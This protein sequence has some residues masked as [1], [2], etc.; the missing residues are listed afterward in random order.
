MTMGAGSQVCSLGG[1]SLI[2]LLELASSIPI[3]SRTYI[4]FFI[5]A[6]F[7]RSLLCSFRGASGDLS[8]S[9]RGTGGGSLCLFSSDAPP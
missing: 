5:G 6:S 3:E 7:G 8:P 1:F 4:R 9:S 2:S